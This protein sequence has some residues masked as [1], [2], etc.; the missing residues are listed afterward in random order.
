MH[1]SSLSRLYVLPNATHYEFDVNVYSP[2]GTVVFEALVFIENPND[3]IIVYLF[4]NGPY[5]NFRPFSINGMNDVSYFDTMISGELLFTITTDE[6]LSLSDDIMVYDFLL[7]CSLFRV[8]SELNISV[9]HVMLHKI[10]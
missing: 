8:T 4:F 2:I 3:A 1:T 9:F 7:E 10:G 6:L 5:Q